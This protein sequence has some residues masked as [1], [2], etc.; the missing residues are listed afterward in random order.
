MIKEADLAKELKNGVPGGLYFFYGD[1]DY[2]K[3]RRAADMKRAAVGEDPSVAAFNCFEF[4]FGDG[5]F[6][7]AAVE[8]ALLAPPMM[9]PKKYISMTFS[10]VDS[11]KTRGKAGEGEDG[12]E[13]EPA[14]GSAA[15]KKGGKTQ[16]RLLEY[17]KS[18]GDPGE[19]TVMVVKAV[20]GGFDPGTSKAPSPFLRD[21]DKFMT[22]VEFPYQSDI[23]LIHWMERH[24]ADYGLT[25]APE[26]C[27]WILNA[28]G[29]SMY[30]LSGEL[31]KTAAYAAYR[32][33][34]EGSPRVVTMEDARLCVASNDEDDAFGLANCIMDGDM[35]GALNLLRIKMALR[36]EPLLILGQISRAISDLYAAAAFSSEGRDV[37]DYAAAMKMHS[38]KA[39]LTYR[40]VGKN[41]P[42]RY[43]EALNL[44][45]EADR[46]MKSGMAGSSGSTGSGGYAPIERLICSLTSLGSASSGKVS[47]GNAYPGN[48]YSGRRGGR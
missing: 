42:S 9:S 8:D 24:F 38:Y 45:L 2:V 16:N 10:S 23:R 14:A 6:D 40:A 5:E 18:V 1:E 7:A 26:V 21:A 34:K 32:A 30:R 20:G 22:C 39:G 29:K 15:G 41:P 4:V 3:N 19:D 43:A 37:S 47:S 44:C 33:E 13:D 11:L 35:A 25:P 48:T 28:A 46:R 17:L 31:A 12:E 36:E 27:K